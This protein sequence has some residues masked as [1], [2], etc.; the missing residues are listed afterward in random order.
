MRTSDTIVEFQNAHSD[1]ARILEGHL[2]AIVLSNDHVGCLADTL[3][4]WDSSCMY[5]TCHELCHVHTRRSRENVHDT[6]A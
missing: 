1:E 2:Q 3:A 5:I 6:L 4:L